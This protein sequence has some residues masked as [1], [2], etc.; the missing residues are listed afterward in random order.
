MSTDWRPDDR[1]YLVPTL[2]TAPRDAYRM[3]AVTVVRMVDGVR[4]T[5]QLGDG[6]QVT[7]DVRNL[8]RHRPAPLDRTRHPARRPAPMP[9]GF[10]EV[11]LW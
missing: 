9:D 10:A 5:V 3:P 2:P 7:T 8:A 6:S 1:G 11:T 4:V